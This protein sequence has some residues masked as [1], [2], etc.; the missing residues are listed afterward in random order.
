MASGWKIVCP[1]GAERHPPY[2]NHGD[3]AFD[4]KVFAREKCD[5]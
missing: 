2:F 4:A 1:D 5:A 3:A